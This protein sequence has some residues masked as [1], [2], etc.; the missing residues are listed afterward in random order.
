MAVDGLRSEALQAALRAALAGR[1]A[2]LADLLAR[3]GGAQSGRPNLRLAVAFGAELATHPPRA[4][5]S[6]LQ[7][8]GADDAPADSAHVFLPIVAAYGWTALL[9]RQESRSG[10]RG[11]RGGDAG[12][13]GD[14]STMAAW[15]A[16]RELAADERTPV[17]IGTVDALVAYAAKG[18]ARRLLMHV[19]AWLDQ[20]GSADGG[21][22][23]ASP[24]SRASRQGARDEKFGA[25]AVAL[26]VLGDR[27]VLA[28]LSDPTAITDYLSRV[29]DEI[30]EAPRAAER[31]DARRRALAALPGALAGVA[32]RWNGDERVLSW[33]EA[34]CARARHP[35]VRAALSQA[36]VRLGESA[37]AEALGAAASDRLRRALQGSAKPPRD[38]SRIRPG[39]GRG[40]VSRRIR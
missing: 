33:L 11:D 2:A 24:R 9:D 16:L 6:L 14:D 36:V 39:H 22:G 35:D 30:A 19:T 12:D 28:N 4:A 31:S 29:T 7:E 38:P 34:E 37:R 27:R 26:D 18:G 1:P 15:D 17:R 32:L 5:R 8:L 23:G 20:H 10:D 21:A 40:R 3:H 13:R 25:T